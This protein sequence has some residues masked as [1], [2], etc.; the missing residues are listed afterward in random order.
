MPLLV[1]EPVLFL[2]CLPAIPLTLLSF[3][4][5]FSL[6]LAILPTL[7]A[8]LPANQLFINNESKTFSQCTGFSTA[9]GYGVLAFPLTTASPTRAMYPD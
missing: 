7:L 2:L 4:P 5:E 6:H 8:W 3:F 9:C 1:F